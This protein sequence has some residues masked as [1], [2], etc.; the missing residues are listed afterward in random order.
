MQNSTGSQ[1]GHNGAMTRRIAKEKKNNNNKKQKKT[2][3][4]IFHAY[5]IY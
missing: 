1:K 2:G 3:P 4:L 5:S